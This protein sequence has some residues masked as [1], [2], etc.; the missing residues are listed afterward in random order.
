MAFGQT[1]CEPGSDERFRDLHDLPPAPH[2]IDMNQ[3]LLCAVSSRHPSRR[4]GPTRVIKLVIEARPKCTSLRRHCLRGASRCRTASLASSPA[5]ANSLCRGSTRTPRPAPVPA[6]TGLI[7]NISFRIA[8]APSPLT[9]F[10]FSGAKG[11]PPHS[12]SATFVCRTVNPAPKVGS[13]LPNAPAS[14]CAAAQ[15]PCALGP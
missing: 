7:S 1:P 8:A 4:P 6:L 11:L 14:S 15:G 5:V 2:A 10:R 12:I 13:I 3:L 9:N